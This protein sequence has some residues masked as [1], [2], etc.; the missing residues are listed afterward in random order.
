MV[1]NSSTRCPAECSL[2]YGRQ[3]LGVMADWQLHWAWYSNPVVCVL[4]LGNAAQANC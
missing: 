1:E 4:L 3:N 2:T